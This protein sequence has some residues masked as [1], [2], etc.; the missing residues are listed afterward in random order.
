MVPQREKLISNPVVAV[1]VANKDVLIDLLRAEI[2]TLR[3]LKRLDLPSCAPIEI[4]H[5]SGLKATEID[6]QLMYLATLNNYLLKAL[7]GVTAMIKRK[8]VADYWDE[9]DIVRADEAIKLAER[10][11]KHGRSGNT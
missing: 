10:K 7:K 2:A 11:I 6:K 9:V 3:A 8:K 1:K 5:S 4:F